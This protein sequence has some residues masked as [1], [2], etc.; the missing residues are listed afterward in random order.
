MLGTTRSLLV[1]GG[2]I[3][4][5]SVGLPMDVHASDGC[6]PLDPT[7]DA[8]GEIIDGQ[9]VYGGGGEAADTGPDMVTTG[10]GRPACT[11][12][13]AEEDFERGQVV[14]DDSRIPMNAV[15][16]WR[17][18]DGRSELLWYVPGEPRSHD[19]VGELVERVL[20]QLQPD[21]PAVVTSPPV[22]S[23]VLTGLPMYLA[24]DA[25]AFSEQ[26][27]SVSAGQFTVTATVTPVETVF[28][29]GDDGEARTCPGSGT[30]WS[31]GDRPDGSACTHTY[32]HTPAHL[33]G[34]GDRFELRARV[35]YEASYSVEGPVLAGTYELGSFEGPESVVEVPVVERRA[36]RTSGS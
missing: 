22:G 14:H 5:A 8:G 7:C 13:A 6:N 15:F 16:Y 34:D 29:P 18:C 9:V 31:R 11:Y 20:E 19:A 27:G 23:Q 36:V 28:V 3:A 12:A 4:L 17:H 32:T 35:L 1:I 24:V 33:H 21:A 2:L 26:S 25:G 10:I 30:V